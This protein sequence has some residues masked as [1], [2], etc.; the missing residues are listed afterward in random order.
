MKTWLLSKQTDRFFPEGTALQ[1]IA[2]T[3]KKM[4][5]MIHH[6]FKMLFPFHFCCRLEKKIPIERMLSPESANLCS[7]VSGDAGF[8]AQEMGYL[9]PGPN[10]TTIKP[11]GKPMGKGKWTQ[12]H[13]K[14]MKKLCNYHD[15]HRLVQGSIIFGEAMDFQV[16]VMGLSVLKC[17]R[18]PIHW[19]SHHDSFLRY[20]RNVM[21]ANE[22][23][24]IPNLVQCLFQLWSSYKV[25]PPQL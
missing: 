17:S 20:H 4:E 12:Y 24:G 19:W 8:T 15:F 22:A 13:R 10:Q 3:T 6:D 18:K 11:M 7:H 23:S 9:G 1:I 21:I 5:Q 25:V 2:V 16:K 14:S